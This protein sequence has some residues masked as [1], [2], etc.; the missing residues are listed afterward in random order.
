MYII[1]QGVP[2]IHVHPRGVGGGRRGGGGGGKIT[3]AKG[4]KSRL[5]SATTSPSLIEKFHIDCQQ[6]PSSVDNW[7]GIRGVLVIHLFTITNND[8]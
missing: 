8:K 7:Y 5:D 1:Y 4:D 2:S 6:G 3:P